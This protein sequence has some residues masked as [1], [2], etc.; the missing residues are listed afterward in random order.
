MAGVQAPM[1]WD[2]HPRHLLFFPM[3]SPDPQPAPSRHTAYLVRTCWLVSSPALAS[4]LPWGDP[5]LSAG[6]RQLLLLHPW[7]L[8]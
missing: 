4:L 6:V 1:L 8:G 3:G 5:H 7:G 2:L